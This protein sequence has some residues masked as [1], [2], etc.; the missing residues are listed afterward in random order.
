MNQIYFSARQVAKARRETLTAQQAEIAAYERRG[1]WYLVGI[2][3]I[4]AV[5]AV[6][7]VGWMLS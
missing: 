3:L 4:S 6:V 1:A 7:L 5:M 2:V